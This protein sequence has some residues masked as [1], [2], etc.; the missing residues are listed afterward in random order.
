VL[1]G[2]LVAVAGG[3]VIAFGDL[4]GDA[5][6]AAAPSPLLGDALA[7]IGAIAIAGYLLLGR[8][9]QRRGLGIDAYAG[10]AY[11]VAALVLMPLPAIAG[12]SYLDYPI[13]TFGWI[14][15]L[16]L[17]PQLIG[18]TGINYAMRHLDPTRVATATLLEPL[19]AAL[20]ALAVFAEVPSPATAIGAAIVLVGVLMTV[21]TGR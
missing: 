9:A 20:L 6:A 16:A 2:V 4:L 12:L 18:H 1:L 17:V 7:L 3:A 8:T 10:V 5:P 15:A 11:A 13:A 19:G 14:L 21:R